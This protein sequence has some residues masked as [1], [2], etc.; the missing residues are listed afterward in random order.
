[1]K[2]KFIFTNRKISHRA[3]MAVI[4]GVISMISLGVLVFQAY[5]AAGEVSVK[6]G[7][8]GLLSGIYS[9]IGLAL[10]LV[11]VWEKNYYRLFPVLGIIL[12]MAALAGVGLILYMGVN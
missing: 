8:I 6:H 1:M 12:N 11:T 7:I 5:E 4:L 3:V 10:G 2:K 9:L